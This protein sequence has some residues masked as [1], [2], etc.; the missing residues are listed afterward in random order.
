M[1]LQCVH[2][3]E[4]ALLQAASKLAMKD[5]QETSMLRKFVKIQLSFAVVI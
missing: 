4:A 2:D 1:M 5:T 3:E